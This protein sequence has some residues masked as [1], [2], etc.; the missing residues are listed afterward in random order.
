MADYKNDL[1]NRLYEIAGKLRS[2]M[3]ANEYKNY[4]LGFIF[5]KY[6]SEKVELTLNKKLE[7]DNINFEEAFKN[8]DSELQEILEQES[9]TILGYF[10]E[11]K[12]L[13][14]TLVKEA[15]KGTFI[16]N[17]L[18]EAFT[19]IEESALK[20]K[21]NVF[22]GLFH[23]VDLDSQKLGKIELKLIKKYQKFSFYYPKS[24]SN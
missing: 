15:N 24:I 21:S 7:N 13:F 3:D 22:D 5:Y 1:N 16:L 20:S 23:D 9:V 14:S 6:L 11:P 4:I 17:D 10:I 12:Y 18:K 8:N 2:N 19:N